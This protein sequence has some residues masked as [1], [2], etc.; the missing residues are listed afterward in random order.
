MTDLGAASNFELE[1]ARRVLVVD[2]DDL[3]RSGL[4]AAMELR[5]FRVSVAK[6][7]FRGLEQVETSAFDLAIV[8]IF[9]PGMDG[10]EFIRE[11]R[12]RGH[13]LPVIIMSGAN[14]S[15]PLAFGSTKMPDYLKMAMALGAVRTLQKPFSPHELT[16]AIDACFEDFATGRRAPA[17]SSLST[18]FVPR[19]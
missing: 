8:D 14:A 2:D 6:N 4:K 7:G 3:I 9:M 19:F 1:V 10:F 15:P 13:P 5:G 16:Q 11:L 17:P 18:R 12:M